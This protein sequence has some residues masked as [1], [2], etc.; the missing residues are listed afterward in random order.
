M[1]CPGLIF[2]FA[3]Q[4]EMKNN[5]F[6]F[7][8]LFNFPVDNVAVGDVNDNLS[9]DDENYNTYNNSKT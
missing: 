3:K 6:F 1:S 2:V 4:L 7:F 5:F 9:D 8:S